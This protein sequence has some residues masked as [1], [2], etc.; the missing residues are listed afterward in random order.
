MTLSEIHEQTVT[1]DLHSLVKNF[2]IQSNS[3]MRE[4][5]I[6][7]TEEMP[8]RGIVARP[9]PQSLMVTFCLLSSCLLS[10]CLLHRR[11]LYRLSARHAT[12]LV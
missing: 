9:Y 6:E 4:K 7:F 11:L 3:H 2:L 8:E 5:K 12:N 1:Q 10:H